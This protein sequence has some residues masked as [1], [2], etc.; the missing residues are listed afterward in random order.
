MILVNLLEFIFFALNEVFQKFTEFQNMVE[1]LFDT[2]IVV[3][4]T[5][6]EV[7]IKS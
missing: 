7:R 2:K 4:Q 1:H 6:W 5:E 3:M